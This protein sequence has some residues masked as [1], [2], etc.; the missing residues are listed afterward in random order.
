MMRS[1]KPIIA[2]NILQNVLACSLLVLFFIDW[3]IELIIRAVLFDCLAG[4]ARLFKWRKLLK[5]KNP[6]SGNLNESLVIRAWYCGRGRF[7]NNCNKSVRYKYRCPPRVFV[8]IDRDL[9]MS[10]IIEAIIVSVSMHLS[11]V[12]PPTRLSLNQ[13][14]CAIDGNPTR[15]IGRRTNYHLIDFFIVDNWLIYGCRKTY[16]VSSVD[17]WLCWFSLFGLKLLKFDSFTIEFNPSFPKIL[18]SCK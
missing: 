12:N 5:I 14:F 17:L 2:L 7:T 18:L 4:S 6:W 9:R 10:T 15:T 1:W 8:L 3:W 13:H 11:I 16:F